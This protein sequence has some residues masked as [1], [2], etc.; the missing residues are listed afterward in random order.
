[1]HI[2]LITRQETVQQIKNEKKAITG[3]YPLHVLKCNLLFYFTERTLLIIS[4]KVIFNMIHIYVVSL[5]QLILSYLQ[6][7]NYFVIITEH[8]NSNFKRLFTYRDL[9]HNWHFLWSCSSSST[10]MAI[11]L[12][13]FDQLDFCSLFL[14]HF[15]YLTN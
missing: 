9:F 2:F 6:V 10:T 12:Y 5:I 1:M 4:V 3:S 11:I 15:Y 13:S 8:Y 7:Q 14:L